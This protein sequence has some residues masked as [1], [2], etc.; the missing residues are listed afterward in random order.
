MLGL[1]GLRRRWRALHLRVEELEGQLRELERYVEELAADAAYAPDSELGLN[2]QSRRKEIVED[3]FDRIGFDRVVETGTFWGA[4]S[5]YF[6]FRFGVPVHTSELLPRN[7]HMAAR[8]LRDTP[9]VDLRLLDSRALLRSLAG[10]SAN[11]SGRT[12]FYLDAH[13][14]D[15]LP[16]AEEIELIAGS[17]QDF[18]ILVDDFA[19]AGDAG[20]GYDDYGPGRALDASY[21]SGLLSRHGL[22]LYYPVASSS[23]ETGARRGCCVIASASMAPSVAACELLRAA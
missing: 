15:D 4:T 21:V 6:A 23:E 5:A 20:Y 14:Y 11:T 19:V 7:H 13:W 18:A 3:L 1:G 22:G 9:G 17:W 2:G 16:L 12:F 8:K 10:D